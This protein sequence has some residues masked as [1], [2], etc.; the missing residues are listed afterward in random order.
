MR[1]LVTGATGLIGRALLMQLAQAG[2]EIVA[3]VRRPFEAP[4]GVTVEQ[5]D[6]R[7]SAMVS[8]AFGRHYPEVV[9]HLA[10]L[11]QFACEE[12][13][14]LAVDINV[15]GTVNLLEA[16]R[17]Y[18]ICRM[19]FGSSVAVYGRRDDLMH[20]DDPPSPGISVYGETKR[21]GEILGA[22]Y[23]ALYGSEFIALRYSGIFGPGAAASRGMALARHLIKSTAEKPHV[24]VP[25]VSG[26][27][28][29]HLTYLTDAVQATR[30]IALRDG[31][32]PHTVY[33]IGGPDENLL[34]LRQFHDAVRRVVPS[35]GD[36]HYAG[37]AARSLGPLDTSRL[38]A[39]LGFR[40]A[41][42]VDD[43]LRDEF[44]S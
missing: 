41:Y 16:C 3:L 11:L 31:P 25:D 29:V 6:I 36:V 13:P 20:E 38:R 35:A 17:R 2:H 21:L 33:N 27:E 7:D 1:I 28:T 26:D 34:S 12:D 10:A 37:P 23:S 32:L 14:H 30:L 43:G 22:R 39:D 24:E 40:P 4:A 18:G 8:A 42:S 5:A 9:I 19:V 15:N 44:L